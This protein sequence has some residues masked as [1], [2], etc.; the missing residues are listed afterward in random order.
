MGWLPFKLRSFLIAPELVGIVR[1][2]LHKNTDGISQFILIQL[3]VC[4]VSWERVV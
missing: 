2:P 3:S 4:E 1:K